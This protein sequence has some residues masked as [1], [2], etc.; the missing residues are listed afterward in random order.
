MEDREHD[1]DCCQCYAV[2]LEVMVPIH[3]TKMQSRLHTEIAH[4]SIAAVS[5]H[6]FIC[7][8]I[9]MRLRV[10]FAIERVHVRAIA[11]AY[12]RAIART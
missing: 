6:A 1:L 11:C 7:V 2:T 4:A 12:V 9:C 8:C 10:L 5:L 3:Y